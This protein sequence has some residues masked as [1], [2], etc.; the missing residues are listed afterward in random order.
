M[1]SKRVKVTNSCYVH[2]IIIF[3]R[4]VNAHRTNCR[5]ENELRKSEK[6]GER[7]WE[8]GRERKHDK[9]NVTKWLTVG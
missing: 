5:G 1:H 3:K 6:E 4:V 9:I 8:R 7:G 2:F